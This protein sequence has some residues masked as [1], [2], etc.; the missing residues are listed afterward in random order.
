MTQVKQVKTLNPTLTNLRE[1]E[2]SNSLKTGGRY[3][4]CVHTQNLCL[5]DDVIYP[6]TKMRVT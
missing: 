3:P 2:A 4:T 6:S 5:D 1:K